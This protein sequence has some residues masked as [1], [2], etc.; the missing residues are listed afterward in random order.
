MSKPELRLPLPTMTVDGW[1]DTLRVWDSTVAGLSDRYRCVRFTLPGFDEPDN[2]RAYELRQIIDAIAQVVDAASPNAP[3][4]LLLHDWGCFFGYQYAMQHPQRVLRVVGVD[5]GDAGSAAHVASLGLRAKLGTVAYQWWLALAWKLGGSIGHRMARWLAAAFRA[6][7]PPQDIFSG[8]GYPYAM[9]WFG[10]AG[11]FGRP[12]AFWPAV[13]MLF[14]HG[15]RKPFSFHST[16]WAERLAARP[17]SRVVGLPT[18]HW[19][20]TQKPELFNTAVRSW[21]AETDGGIPA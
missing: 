15:E 13:P 8:M 16:A 17:G 2:R 21:L 19:V 18:G 11:G 5:I 9:Q 3:V 6:P 14:I 20:M 7:A 1:P 4:T 12:R 10:A